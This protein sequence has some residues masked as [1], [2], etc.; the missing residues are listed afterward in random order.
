[1]QGLL[2]IHLNPDFWG[3]REHCLEKL[4]PT[5]MERLDS[6]I[7]KYP[8]LVSGAFFL[9]STSRNGNTFSYPDDEAGDKE[10]I[11]WSR[12]SG[13]HEILCA[14]NLAEEKYACVYVTVDEA[15]HPIDSSM[16]C[17][18]ASDLSPAELNIEVRN[19]KAIR[20]TIPPQALVIYC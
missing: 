13:D 2:D 6:L 17:L 1:M 3:V 5:Q 10:V 7:R 20:L 16:K 8:T 15:M 19:G 14:V 9:R 18:F 11:A 4:R 12:I